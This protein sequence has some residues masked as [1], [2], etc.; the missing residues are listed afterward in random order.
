VEPADWS[1][2]LV[3]PEPPGPVSV[4]RRISS[5]IEQLVHLRQLVVAAQKRR[6][7]DR[8]IRSVER[9]QRR[10]LAVPELEDPLRRAQVP[11]PVLAEVAQAVVAQQRG[12]RRGDEHLAS[13]GRSRDPGGAVDVLA[14]VPLAVNS[15]VPV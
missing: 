1:A 9:L 11:K 2:S 6:G 12:G 10:E 14:D 15:G 8:E 4:S 13:V 5:E 7:R 3:F